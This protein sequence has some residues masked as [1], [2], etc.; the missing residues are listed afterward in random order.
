M[1]LLPTGY[2][3]DDAEPAGFHYQRRGLENLLL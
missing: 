3:A 1:A 2:P